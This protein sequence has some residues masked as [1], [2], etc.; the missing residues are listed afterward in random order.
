M[1]RV[2]DGE[3]TPIARVSRR[4]RSRFLASLLGISIASMAVTVSIELAA[5]RSETGELAAWVALLDRASTA[6]GQIRLVLRQATALREPDDPARERAELAGAVAAL[7]EAHEDSVVGRVAERRR[8]AL[9]VAVSQLFFGGSRSLDRGVRG[10]VA[11]ATDLA[12]TPTD[13]G[14]PRALI[15]L[16]GL[17]AAR[18]LIDGYDAIVSTYIAHLSE[19]TRAMD[20]PRY[21]VSLAGH[22]L[23]VGW[24]GLLYQRM[25]H[26][27]RQDNAHHRQVRRELVR[28]SRELDE[29]LRGLERSRDEIQNRSLAMLSVLEDLRGERVRL[30]REIGERT[31]AEERFRAVVEAAPVGQV[32]VSKT[33]TIRLVNAVAE[34][35]FGYPR[36]ELIGQPVEILVP[37][38]PRGLHPRHRE[39]FWK[40]PVAR[41]MGAG[42]HLYARRKDGREVP[43]EIGL[44]P[45]VTDEGS[46][47]LTSVVDI[48]ERLQAER[49]LAQ[50]NRD[51]TRKN[52]ELEQFVYTV[53]HDLKSPMVTIS[54]FA[55]HIAASAAEL[56]HD[57]LLDAAGRVE[58]A[59]LRLR[60]TL[61]D[62][63]DLSRAGRTVDELVRIDLHQLLG[64]AVAEH[65]ST[66]ERVGLQVEVARELPIIHADPGRLREV[67][68]NL[69]TNAIRYASGEG[70]ARVRIGGARGG[71]EAR[72]YVEDDGPGIPAEFHDRVFGLFVRLASAG[73]GSGVGLA[74]V[75]RILE[76]HRGR[77][78]IESPPEGRERGTRVWLGF[79]DPLL[80]TWERRRAEGDERDG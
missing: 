29:A 47:V 74:I 78:W 22:L 9:P 17:A 58:R 55:G 18:E 16:A 28:H 8:V 37:E 65:A 57:G 60:K 24:I 3:T 45:L 7:R 49:A 34:R 13:P 72:L 10:F 30:D 48:T 43:V 31:R 15:S 46:A 68:D 40:R 36:E 26:R 69:L 62:L 64:A 33:G 14:S 50:A 80:S 76:A 2:S 52:D 32:L 59:A 12:S 73:E 63:L 35:T 75:K 66:L 21:L 77:V 41:P 11:A 27:L 67:F 56:G 23:L 4:V 38:R 42:R 54:G 61:D 79:P 44:S 51:L 53:S 71:G 6:R 5:F 25:L 70:A 20:S 19:R 39:E 1:T